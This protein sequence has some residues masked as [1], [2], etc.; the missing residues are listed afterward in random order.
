VASKAT[1]RRSCIGDP[2][3]TGVSAAA[4]LAV[5]VCS[6]TAESPGDSRSTDTAVA[7]SLH[8]Y[9]RNDTIIMETRGKDRRG[10]HDEI[11]FSENSRTP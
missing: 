6:L 7:F 1:T 11:E 9:P 10:E 5:G 4:H 3:A 2:L 8:S